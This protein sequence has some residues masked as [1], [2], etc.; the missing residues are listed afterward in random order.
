MKT[1]LCILCISVVLLSGIMGAVP[2]YAAAAD[3][4]NSNLRKAHDL[5]TMPNSSLPTLV[6]V[7][8]GGLV[9][10]MLL[11]S[12]KRGRSGPGLLAIFRLIRHNR[13]VR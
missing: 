12:R 13:T 9:G 2:A 7:G 1:I 5:E 4:N 10:I 11:K 3:N 6:L 8:L